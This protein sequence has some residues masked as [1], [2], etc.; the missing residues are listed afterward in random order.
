ML[1]TAWLPLLLSG[2]MLKYVIL[3]HITGSTIH[4]KNVVPFSLASMFSCEKPGITQAVIP[5]RVA[6]CFVAV[7]F[8][9]YVRYVFL[10]LVSSFLI[11]MCLNS[12]TIILFGACLAS[13]IYRSF[14]KIGTFSTITSSIFRHHA[15]SLPL[16]DAGHT[17]VERFVIVPQAPQAPL[18]ALWPALEALAVPARQAL[19]RSAASGP[20]L[21]QDGEKG[22]FWDRQRTSY[23][24]SCA[25][26]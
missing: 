2:V 17:A 13:Q 26:P 25:A 4:L 6:H 9:S 7:I 19:L 16:R 12:F 21:R 20:P 22:A 24:G 14:S 8:L 1:H 15:Q 5:L 11:T 3:I 23:C 10:C 18:C